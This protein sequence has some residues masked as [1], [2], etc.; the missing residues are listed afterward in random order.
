MSLD[1]NR[2]DLERPARDFIDAALRRA[3]ADWLSGDALPFERP[4]YE[5]LLT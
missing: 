3:V 1:E 4:L 5:P 2:A